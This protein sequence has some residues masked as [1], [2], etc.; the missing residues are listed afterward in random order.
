MDHHCAFT[1]N[2]IGKKNLKY[3]FHFVGWA[4]V[5]LSVGM[6]VV[7]FNIFVRNPVHNYG[8]SNIIEIVGA[9]PQF[10][11]IKYLL[12]YGFIA[13]FNAVTLD[14]TILLG[15]VFMIGLV[16]TPAV[17]TFLNIRTG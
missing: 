13:Q 5:A 14:S 8:A 3:F 2:C 4:A 17:G 16:A 9:F 15:L 7:L 12:G 6:C 1:D 10:I 11:G